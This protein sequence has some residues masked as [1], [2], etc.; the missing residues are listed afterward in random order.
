MYRAWLTLAAIPLFS[1]AA[2]AG[3]DQGLLN[4]V[5]AGSKALSGVQIDKSK[6]SPFG[7]YVLGRML[8]GGSSGF[9]GFIQSTGFDPR[10]DVQELLFATT[11]DTG[12]PRIAVLARGYFD[13][14]K[15]KATALSH[16]SQIEN[17][18]G[19]NVLWGGE[20]SHAGVAVL[21][22][23]LAVAGDRVLVESIVRN[24]RQA[25]VLDSPELA[26][27]AQTASSAGEV[28]FVSLIPGSALPG[29]AMVRAHGQQLNGAVV[30]SI[31]QS[32]GSVH[33]SEK[34]IELSFEALTRS[35]RDAQSLA[36]VARFCT[37]M[38]QMQSENHAGAKLLA[39]SLDAMQLAT[40]GST[41]SVSIVL[42]EAAAEQLLSMPP[43][44]RKRAALK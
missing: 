35:E 3:V 37:S 23:T 4:L 32:Q 9:D 43:Q 20:K 30:Q 27:K 29:K 42:P 41:M 11:A 44:P 18:Q 7:Q 38:V 22:P 36:D 14:A 13:A 5:P 33:F 25:S 26:E 39:G 12:R 15:I 28:W 19:V 8:I 24:R 21:D 10:R 2:L 17:I 31:L 40:H 16:G 1:C 34:G 6:D